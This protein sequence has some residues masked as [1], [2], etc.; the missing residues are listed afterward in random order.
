M[1]GGEAGPVSDCDRRFTIG[2][3]SVRHIPGEINEALARMRK[4]SGTRGFVKS[5]RG[6]VGLRCPNYPRT[7]FVSQ[8]PSIGLLGSGGFGCWGCSSFSSGFGCVGCWC[9]GF[10]LTRSGQ[11]SKRVFFF[12]DGRVFSKWVL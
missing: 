1:G 2:G 7:C 9:L 4:I 8:I 3:V 10:D 12:F 11:C 6:W 5:L